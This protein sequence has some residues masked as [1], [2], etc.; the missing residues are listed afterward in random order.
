MHF[1]NATAR[2]AARHRR[3]SSPATTRSWWK[4][5][6]AK[7]V[8]QMRDADGTARSAHQRRHAA[9]G[10]RHPPAPRPGR[11]A[12]RDG[13]GASARR[14]ASRRS[15]RSTQN[16]AKFS[17]SDRQMP[18]RVSLRRERAPQSRDA[19]EPAG[20]DRQRRRGAAQG[21]RRHQLR[22]RARRASA[23]TTRA[24]RLSLEADLNGVELGPAHEEDPARCRSL[25]NLPPGVQIVDVG[26]AQVHGRAVHE[27]R[28]RDGRRHPAGVRGAGAAVRARAPADHHSGRA[29]AV[30]RRR[31][32]GA[33]SSP[34]I[35]SRWPR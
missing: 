9:A 24:P 18:I 30:A 11:A 3:S 34:A 6:R 35:R 25:K 27:L 13:G 21:G 17:L 22:R 26:D 8:E 33:R 23:A 12:R 20:A 10:N 32:G 7:L 29:A 16:S 4:P 19:R 14:S 28:A 15:A 1:Q 5:A 31:G 2:A